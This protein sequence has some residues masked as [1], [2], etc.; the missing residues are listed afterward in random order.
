VEGRSWFVGVV[1]QFSTPTR[2][3]GFAKLS[4]YGLFTW[5]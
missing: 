5:F 2:E 3:R 4:K 1:P